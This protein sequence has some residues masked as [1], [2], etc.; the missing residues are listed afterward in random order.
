MT[1]LP[2]IAFSVKAGGAV[3]ALTVA[4]GLATH[5]SAV[6]PLDVEGSVESLSLKGGVATSGGQGNVF[7]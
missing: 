1:N 4:G 6:A 2:A 7:N 5:G 3:R